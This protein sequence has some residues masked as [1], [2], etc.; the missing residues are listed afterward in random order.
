MATIFVSV[1]SYRDEKC[2]QTIRSLFDMARQPH[3]VFVGICE[4]NVMDN[5][6]ETCVSWEDT[7]LRKFFKNIRRVIIPNTDARGPCYARYL[8]SLLYKG[9]DYFFQIDSHSLL[10]RD[11]DLKCIRMLNECPNPARS[12]LSYYPI[13]DDQYTPDPEETLAIPVI[14][15]FIMNENGLFQWNAA[16]YTDLGGQLHRS[17]YIAA[18]FLFAPG[19]FVVNVPY[20]PNLPYLFMGEEAL[21]TIRAFTSGYDIYTPRLSILYHT[22]IRTERPSVYADTAS[23]EGHEE[24]ILRAKWILGL[25][26]EKPPLMEDDEDRY[27][28]GSVRTY[29]EYWEAI[30]Y[31]PREPFMMTR[32][33]RIHPRSH[34]DIP[35]Y[36]GI[37]FI[38]CLGVVI[39]AVLKKKI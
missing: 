8:C 39:F 35:P 10:V 4:Q 23:R 7:T 15:S 2:L 9:E 5:A 30:G 22:Y 13:Q 17:P 1:A 6:S 37:V 33:D 12:I 32:V 11:W 36:D 27:G 19:D 25:T 28:L 31:E 38:L 20:D 16:T 3:R 34:H 29:Q 21:L 26:D 18:G 24:A 14:S